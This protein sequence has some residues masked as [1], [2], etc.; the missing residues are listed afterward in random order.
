MSAS[1]NSGVSDQ[2]SERSREIDHARVERHPG[3]KRAN[4]QRIQATAA[5]RRAVFTIVS[6]NYIAYAAT[7]MQSAA[8]HIA[9]VDRF[10]ILSDTRRDFPDLNLSA[11]LL[12][13]S[14]LGIQNLDNM[15]LWY[16]V[17]E[18]NTAIKPYSF[19]H[20]F[21]H[22]CYDEA[23][24]IDPD[25]LIL[26]T[27]TEVFDALKYHS[28]VLT[29][30]MLDPLQD[31]K[32]PS[33]ITI[34]KSGIYNLGFLGLRND[35]DGV[36][37]AG[38]WADRCFLHCRVDIPGHMFTDQRW[39]DLA[40]AFVTR[41]FILR[42]P[43]YNVAYWNLL[44]RNVTQNASGRWMANGQPL[45]F[46]HFSGIN[47]D[48]PEQFSKHQDRFTPENLGEV[49]TLCDIYRALVLG[50]K[51]RQY[52]KT[53]YGF[54]NF[55][56]GRRIDDVMRHWI[57][58]S[59]DEKR[60][61]P[62]Q[63]LNFTSDFLDGPAEFAEGQ[64]GTIMT[65]YMHQL[66]LD[67]GDLRSAFNIFSVSGLDSYF[68]WFVEGDAI[69]QGV[70]RRSIIAARTLRGLGEP[71]AP[72]PISLQTP[73]WKPVCSR[74]L[75]DNSAE[76]L[77]G[78]AQDVTVDVAGV[79][80]L[81]PTQAAILWERRR[82]LQDAFDLKL[83]DKK[84]EFLCWA[85]T[86]GLSDGAVD[87]SCISHEF[88]E[89]FCELS[90][91]AS[92][93]KDVPVTRGMILLRQVST[94]RKAVPG[95]RGFPIEPAG[96]IAHGV[97]F[98]FIAPKLFGWPDS[99]VA[100]V[101]TFFH[102]PTNI[103]TDGFQLNRLAVSIWEIRSDLQR[104]YPL[105]DQ[106][107]IRKFLQWLLIHGLR[108]LGLSLQQ[109]DP[110]LRAFLLSQSPRFE[111]IT[112]LIE[113]MHSH[114]RDLQSMF[115]LSAAEPRRGMIEWA[116]R[117]LRRDA[118]STALGE[119]LLPAD[120]LIVVKQDSTVHYA[121]IALTGYWSLPSGRGED[122][123]G[124]AWALDAVGFRD[125]IV[126][127]LGARAFIRPD[128]T[129]LET[130]CRLEIRTN[131]VH[132]NA[133]TAAEDA[134][135]LHRLGVKSRRV[136]G[137][138]AWELE[139]LPDYWN[140]AYSFYDKIWASTRFA[141]T[142]FARGGLRPV[143]LMPMSVVAPALQS[144][145]ARRDLALPD[146]A[147]VFLFMFDY[148]SYTARKNPDAVIRAFAAAFPTKHE[149]VY[150]LIKTNGAVTHPTDAASLADRVNDPRVEFR[151]VVLD[152]PEL[153]ALIGAS[154]A[155]VSLHRSEG[156]GRG[157]AEAMLLGVPVIVTDY[158]GSAD[159]ATRDCALL[160]DYDLMPVGVDEY[161][162]VAGQ[163]WANAN[164]ATAALHMR[165]VHEHPAEAAALGARGR[166]RIQHLYNTRSVGEAL[167]TGLGLNT[168]LPNRKKDIIRKSAERQ[169]PVQF[170]SQLTS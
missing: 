157:P 9:G 162:G 54:S 123:R 6:S 155:F 69:A 124:S 18:F 29:P 65:S 117:N 121:T 129:A 33:D 38:W 101:R 46:F 86:A 100:N 152:R 128:G 19:L 148:R 107:S 79:T 102:E 144:K 48:K 97:W 110:R 111:G 168:G 150:L 62:K 99:F 134:L 80:V 74:L 93:Y 89:R 147:T 31:G 125:Y 166:A 164:V 16:T 151:D 58:R 94:A 143:D 105:N 44:H 3:G 104:V 43:G 12:D 103:M 160:V 61:D 91:I 4:R 136:I 75:S 45:Q 78:L 170:R 141:E 161:P 7:V 72:E 132:T 106:L 51:W 53:P 84:Y 88:I 114:R 13:C 142:A 163:S 139:W 20:L 25:V 137:F 115:D 154:D 85:L 28:C 59:A 130:G 82:D 108:E 64:R 23:C 109:F 5:R 8:K 92:F 83:P 47:P 167:L 1:S 131:V 126:V 15:K 165:W 24:Y 158:S 140:Y 90:S 113:M 26:D 63:P 98:A 39:M 87:V 81:I 96:R 10:I 55:A 156:F 49:N 14:E 17:I 76:A 40:P 36:R 127:D 71:P 11:D 169:A 57:L 41:A 153:L 149:K 135:L 32:E 21:K 145:A 67:R 119:A 60:I 42:H 73:P 120:E 95:W 138:W 35:S 133:D 77:A 52:S 159:Y 30:H 146:D 66:W 122:V 70:D 50:N 22:L 27:M 37:L 68:N 112:Q 116:D 56:D 34:M 2:S 118:A